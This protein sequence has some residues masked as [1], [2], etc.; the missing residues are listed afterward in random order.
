M[1]SVPF[2]DTPVIL[3]RV[4]EIVISSTHRQDFALVEQAD[5]HLSFT[6]STPA[7]HAWLRSFQPVAIRCDL[8]EAW[9]TCVVK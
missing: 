8:T 9:H 7:E 2:P 5:E 4:A 1:Q 6:G 3:N